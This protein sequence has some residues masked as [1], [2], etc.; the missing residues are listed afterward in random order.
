LDCATGL[1]SFAILQMLYKNGSLRSDTLVSI[2]EPEA[3]LHPQWVVEYARLIV[4][5][6][7]HAGIRF[8]I[9]SHHPDMISAIKYIS[10]K[11]ETTENLNF[12]LAEKV[13]GTY[14]YAYKS[15]GTEIEPIFESFNIAIDRIN[16]YG[17]E[18]A[19]VL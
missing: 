1:K 17:A 7:K 15:L 9:A 10:E 3:H 19:K 4:R 12:Y 18:Q 2:D 8:F 16:Q 6:H 13:S 5:L 14:T 11:E